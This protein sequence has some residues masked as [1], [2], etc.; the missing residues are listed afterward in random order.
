MIE[1][2]LVYI[3]DRLCWLQWANSKAAADGEAPPETLASK[4][5]GIKSENDTDSISYE[6]PEDFERQKKMILEGKVI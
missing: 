6:T 3:Y 4:L 5:F 1:Q 2:L